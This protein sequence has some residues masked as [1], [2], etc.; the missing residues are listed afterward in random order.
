MYLCQISY[1]EVC[2]ATS[3]R[4]DLDLQ[5]EFA[6]SLSPTLQK[7]LYWA[8]C[9][10]ASSHGQEDLTCLRCSRACQRQFDTCHL[11]II[12]KV[13][14]DADLCDAEVQKTDCRLP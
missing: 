10:I 5:P 14:V 13:A 6:T 12:V 11:R 3:G 1:F 2:V 4:S 8:A 7:V 9:L